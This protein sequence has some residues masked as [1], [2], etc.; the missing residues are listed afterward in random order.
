MKGTKRYRNIQFTCYRIFT[1]EERETVF[2]H[3]DVQYAQFQLEECP[4]SKRLHLQGWMQ[5]K[6]QLRIESIQRIF[7]GEKIHVEAIRG[8]PEDNQIYTSKEESKIDG[9]WTYGEMKNP[10]QR[11]DIR[12]VLQHVS[13]GGDVASA[14]AIEDFPID[15][16][17]RNYR[18]FENTHLILRNQPRRH[19]SRVIYLWGP[20]GT[21]KSAR[22]YSAGAKDVQISTS[23]FIM[24]YEHDDVVVFDDIDK[25]TFTRAQAL[26]LFD[27]H[28]CTINVKGMSNVQW[29]PKTIYLTSNYS[30]R[31]V[32]GDDEAIH[33]RIDEVHLLTEPYVH[34]TSGAGDGGHGSVLPVTSESPPLSQPCASEG[35]GGDEVI[36]VKTTDGRTLDVKLN[37]REMFTE[38][39]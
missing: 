30:P 15:T 21:G 25:H 33:R 22:A 19:K 13:S 27:R 8:T 16:Y 4:T 37:F 7:L 5:L 36:T 35:S 28:P 18:F 2:N 14:L 26:K 1:E 23:G 34:A 10:G 38:F 11:T 6:T 24:G 3:P 9:P 20:T 39:F 12:T 32:F 29:N 31:S 17:V